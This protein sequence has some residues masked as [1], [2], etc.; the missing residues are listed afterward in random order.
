MSTSNDWDTTM[1]A[2]PPTFDPAQKYSVENLQKFER[3]FL[4]PTRPEPIQHHSLLSGMYISFGL[5]LELLMEFPDINQARTSYKATRPQLISE[6][7]KMRDFAFVAG[8]CP[9][10][11][12]KEEREATRNYWVQWIDEMM[13]HL[14]KRFQ[15]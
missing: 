13:Q 2:S 4:Y 7:N 5:Y 1:Y 10:D 9:F 3:E 15:G 8:K 6:C 11:A 12:M 14:D